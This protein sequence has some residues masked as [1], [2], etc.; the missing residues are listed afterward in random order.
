M[1]TDEMFAGTCADA[2]I[3]SVEQYLPAERAG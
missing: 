2:I 1:R 3:S